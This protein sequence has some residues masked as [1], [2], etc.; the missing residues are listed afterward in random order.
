M[1]WNPGAASGGL[2]PLPPGWEEKFDSSG[3]A[4]YVDHNTR[5]TTWQRPVWQPPHGQ[6]QSLSPTQHSTPTASP[7]TTHAQQTA[8]NS[9]GSF[10]SASVHTVPSPA[11]SI[12]SSSAATPIQNRF[13]S[14]LGGHQPPANRWNGGATPSPVTQAASNAAALASTQS[15][16]AQRRPSK[17][18]SVRL[19][20]DGRLS[21]AAISAALSTELQN[22]TV[23]F[24]GSIVLQEIGLHLLPY[25]VP[26][27]VA[28][29]CFKCSTKF[30]AF[31]YRH[32][33][34]S[35][36]GVFC[37]KCSSRRIHIPIQ[38]KE[39]ENDVRVCD[40]CHDHLVQGDWFSF[41]RIAILLRHEGSDRTA[42]EQALQAFHLAVNHEPLDHIYL[43]HKYPALFQ[44]VDRLG[45]PRKLWKCF[46]QFLTPAAPTEL[47]AMACAVIVDIQERA[48]RAEMGPQFA[49]ALFE[50]ECIPNLLKAL[51]DP[52]CADAA[53]HILYLLSAHP[54]VAEWFAQ[55]ERVVQLLDALPRMDVPTQCWLLSAFCYIVVGREPVATL[56]VDSTS[57]FFIITLLGSSTLQLQ[58]HAVNALTA[59][60]SALGASQKRVDK[61]MEVVVSG[62]FDGLV[63]LLGSSDHSHVALAVKFLALM[64]TSHL[65]CL[66]VMETPVFSAFA[67]TLAINA[68]ATS[69]TLHAV[70][71]ELLCSF[72]HLAIVAHDKPAFNERT[73][74]VR[75]TLQILSQD[76]R[77]EVIIDGAKLLSVFVPV[78]GLTSG[79]ADNDCLP[80]AVESLLLQQH[81]EEILA[82]LAVVV[83]NLLFDMSVTAQPEP[84]GAV[85][86]P[87]ILSSPIVS[88][89]VA[90][91]EPSTPRALVNAIRL[92]NM[93]ASWPQV[94]I[95]A[96]FLKQIGATDIFQ[97]LELISTMPDT[98]VQAERLLLTGSLCG[99]PIYFGSE[100]D[101][102][103]P[104]L[105]SVA[106]Q[107][108]EAP[109]PEWQ[110]S[111]RQ[112][113]R[114]TQH[115]W[116]DAFVGPS[117]LG[118]AD[119]QLIVPSIRI[120][121]SLLRAQDIAIHL[122]NK[123]P[124]PLAF[125]DAILAFG[126]VAA[127]LA[128]QV[129]SFF[130]VRIDSSSNDAFL[131]ALQNVGVLIAA[132]TNPVVLTR[133]VDT[134]RAIAANNNTWRGIADLI[135]G[136]VTTHRSRSS[137]PQ[138]W[139]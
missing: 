51:E 96:T 73:G 84:A 103:D 28:L 139:R 25:K 39:Y 80:L 7:M 123:R 86:L 47:R 4:F 35:C 117:L 56:V 93:L 109:V 87:Q 30:S 98:H 54:Q 19:S 97:R 128:L 100:D 90:Q 92:L 62:G 136:S 5:T 124:M 72:V 1:S 6:S 75:G 116:F 82:A 135:T 37:H 132:S 26:D 61:M 17:P 38:E 31:V 74:A 20:Q 125:M 32:H 40:Y 11:S 119:P 64:T 130:A 127:S 120:M 138:H 70:N 106:F 122:V 137:P 42:Y 10:T 29:A 43:D 15:Q 46:M 110:H 50:K 55:S 76:H 9:T 133:T 65:A 81:H 131:S 95:Q 34:R 45:G 129:F 52:N 104:S 89:A 101:S 134:I 16:A 83:Y 78:A 12:T 91:L 3:R 67:D 69:P 112:D 114:I 63:A 48:V 71:A 113:M 44:L 79:I 23:P 24:T 57:V 49:Q 53:S 59:V 102:A 66:A 85:V 115:N 13:D 18:E 14:P 36:G 121:H 33:C 68:T 88:S 60:A 77:P 118:K 2:P 58:A 111:F 21:D 108:L 8:F 126:P 94:E 22:L 105:W 107:R 99:A 41:L 27:R